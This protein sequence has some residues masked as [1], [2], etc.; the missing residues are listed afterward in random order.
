[1]RLTILIPTHNRK[2]DL[3]RCLNSIDLNEDF[4]VIISDNA[5]PYDVQ[6]CI[7]EKLRACCTVRRRSSNTG[8]RDN[9]YE[10][11][12]L[13]NGDYSLYITD[14]DYFLRH[15]LKALVDQ[16]KKETNYE[17]GYAAC[18]VSLVKS[19]RTKYYGHLPAC[20]GRAGFILR[21][22]VLSGLI[23]KTSELQDVLT[24]NE[25]L[26]RTTWHIGMAILCLS[27]GPRFTIPQPLLI[28]TWENETYWGIRNN[29]YSILEVDNK[30]LFR[31][32]RDNCHI[33]LF[34]FSLLRLSFTPLGKF[35]YRLAHFANRFWANP[36]LGNPNVV[37]P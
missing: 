20:F 14:D 5:S 15:K 18:V 16:L 26:L 31:T 25:K 21:A 12:R 1:M 36:K 9:L 28:H 13:A 4:E 34:E 7:P 24:K 10:V 3:T 23:I 37:R 27:K 17:V 2:D 30:L 22:H 6:E 33:N 19:N 8:P 35:V 11:G 32:M 29:D